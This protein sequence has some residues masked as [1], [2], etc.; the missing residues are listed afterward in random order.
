MRLFYSLL[1]P[2][3]F[4]SDLRNEG[5]HI[6]EHKIIFILTAVCFEVL[7]FFKICKVTHLNL[8]LINYSL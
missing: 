6:S 8:R 4:I 2:D 7:V 5:F 3:I 1:W